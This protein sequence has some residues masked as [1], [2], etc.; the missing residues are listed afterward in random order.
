[1]NYKKVEKK[2]KKVANRDKQI[3]REIVAKVGKLAAKREKNRR[4][5]EKFF[6]VDLTACQIGLCPHCFSVVNLQ[7]SE[8][9]L[10]VPKKMYKMMALQLFKEYEMPR[11]RC[12]VCNLE[13]WR[14]DH[15]SKTK[16]E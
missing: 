11:E 10:N 12:P 16:I 9:I 3:R 6:Q 13:P 2:E 1:M 4:K 14:V 8:K 7:T 15:E 5:I